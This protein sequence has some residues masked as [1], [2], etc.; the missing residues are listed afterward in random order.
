M[1]NKRRIALEIRKQNGDAAR[2]T[3][4]AGFFSQLQD[5]PDQIGWD[6]AAK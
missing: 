4:Q 6:K 5:T 1:F 3:S 2:F